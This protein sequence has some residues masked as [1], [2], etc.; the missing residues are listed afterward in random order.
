VARNISPELRKILRDVGCTPVREGRAGYEIWHSL[1]TDRHFSVDA[2]VTSR[3]AANGILK[4]AGLP[5]RF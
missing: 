1:I 4:Q 2:E 5:E 3:R